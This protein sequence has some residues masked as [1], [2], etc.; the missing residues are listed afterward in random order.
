MKNFEK[1]KNNYEL[2]ITIG[3]TL[4]SSLELHEVL[5]KIMDHISRLIKP[6]SWSLLLL[7]E[8]TDELYFQILVG[9]GISPE[10]KKRRIK[11]GDGIA[12][13]VA[14]TGEPITLPLSEIAETDT[15]LRE[16]NSPRT[17]SVVCVPLKS[18]GRVLGV[19]ELVKDTG[20]DSL[21]EDER[22]L[23]MTLADYAAI[24]IENAMYFKKV[25]EL[26]IKD[27]V[28]SLY[29]SRHM[30]NV[31]D[32]ELKRAKRYGKPLSL[33]FLDLDFF[34]NINDNYGHLI[35]S[36][37]L[38]EVA[39]LLKKNLREIDVATRYGGDEF[40]LILPETDKEGALKVAYR[41]RNAM[42]EHI[43]L[44]SEKI[45][46]RITASFGV[47]SFPEDTDNKLDLIRLADQ[48]MYRVKL[49]SRDDVEPA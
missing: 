34:K 40:V 30:H 19:I 39:E 6:K 25:Q 49:R 33:I 26:S 23:L 18:K 41:L 46:V 47:A 35:G 36:Q 5:N 3:K 7:D 28:T 32:S 29:N 20:K 4:T 44:K 2:F 8:K 24:A 37:L 31:L 13:T 21:S 48:A 45:A 27:D 9:E 22:I 15:I 11:V 1:S 43:F 10:L 38:R 16:I 14:K 12:G 17:S 42:R